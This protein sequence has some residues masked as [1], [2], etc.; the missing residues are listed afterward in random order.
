MQADAGAFSIS[1]SADLVVGS[2]ATAN[3]TSQAGVGRVK[4]RWSF[5]PEPIPIPNHRV[6]AAEPASFSIS[7]SADFEV[8]RFDRVAYDNEFLLMD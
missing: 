4:F 7:G 2:A 8:K 5:P 3:P 1:G 6:L